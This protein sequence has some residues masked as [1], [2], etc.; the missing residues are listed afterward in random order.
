[1]PLQM[2]G[3][4]TYFGLSMPLG[5]RG[6]LSLVSS[7]HALISSADF[8]ACRLESTRRDVRKVF[9]KVRAMF[10]LCCGLRYRAV[11]LSTNWIYV[12]GIHWGRGGRV[13]GDGVGSKAFNYWNFLS[14]GLQYSDTG[15]D[16]GK[17]QR[18]WK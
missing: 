14:E 15:W 7:M 5:D 8:S 9:L 17:A 10:L 16:R 3:G 2:R 13:V 4:T 6:S 11:C 1:M 12:S 18:P